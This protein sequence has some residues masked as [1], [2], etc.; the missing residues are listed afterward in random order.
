MSDRGNP[1]GGAADA[2][3]TG[4]GTESDSAPPVSE[5]PY[6]IEFEATGCIG[7]GPCASASPNWTLDLD[8]GIASPRERYVAEADLDHNAEAAERCPAKKGAGVI[9]VVDR[10]TGEV[11]APADATPTDDE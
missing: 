2:T 7:A 6:R 8:T 5:K 1:T 9:R 11:V 4:S 3:G 10:R